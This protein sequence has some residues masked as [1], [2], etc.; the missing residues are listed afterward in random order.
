MLMHASLSASTL[1]LQPTVTGSPF[2]TWNLTLAA[3]L[4]A[5]VGAVAVTHP[6]SP[7]SHP[8]PLISAT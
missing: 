6:S 2:A 8:P 5:V 1:I 4:W 7:V 3:L